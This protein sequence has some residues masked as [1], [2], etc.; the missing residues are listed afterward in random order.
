M[1][2]W[3]GTLSK[4]D[5]FS[6]HR[7]RTNAARSLWRKPW[8]RS[9]RRYRS[10]GHLLLSMEILRGGPAYSCISLITST[11]SS[12]VRSSPIIRSRFSHLSMCVIFPA[13][14]IPGKGL[15]RSVLIC[16]RYFGMPNLKIWRTNHLPIRLMD[17][18]GRRYQ[19]RHFDAP[20]GLPS[21]PHQI[22][23]GPVH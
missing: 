1:C 22:K 17:C 16:F 8:R 10:R 21:L 11:K 12:R 6:Q 5:C 15:S 18:S 20:F 13:T 7:Q 4:C 14:G 3:S 2:W 9:I 19:R 23:L